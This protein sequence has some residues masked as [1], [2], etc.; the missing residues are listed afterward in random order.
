MGPGMISQ[1]LV[2]TSATL[3]ICPGMQHNCII[4]PCSPLLSSRISHKRRHEIGRELCPMS[5]RVFL[6][7]DDHNYGMYVEKHCTYRNNS[8]KQT[9]VSFIT[10]RK[11]IL[12]SKKS[13]MHEIFYTRYLDSSL[14]LHSVDILNSRV[15][16]KML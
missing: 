13:T 5:I 7:P 6:S 1:A 12:K 15:E 3:W 4:P 9:A 14:E 16:F 11:P 2:H 10:L 8:G